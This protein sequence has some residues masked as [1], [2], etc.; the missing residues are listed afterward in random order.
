[1]RT[2][3]LPGFTWPRAVTY[4]RALI[5]FGV[6]VLGSHVSCEADHV[7]LSYD[8]GVDSTLNLGTCLTN[9]IGGYKQVRARHQGA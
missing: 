4:E 1:M 3:S 5:V 6:S 2:C 8:V 9:R 7:H